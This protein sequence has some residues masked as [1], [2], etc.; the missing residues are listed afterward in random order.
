MERR[1]PLYRNVL[2]LNHQPKTVPY[3][4]TGEPRGDGEANYGF[5]DVKGRFD[6]LSTIPE[7]V[8]DGSLF[9]LVEAISAPETGLFS[10]GCV[11]GG[12]ADSAGHRR[13]GYVE[14]A[15]NSIAAVSSAASYFPLYFYFDQVL[16]R[17][18]LCSDVQY[19]WELKP[20]SFMDLGIQGYTCAVFVNT[21][22]LKT[23]AEALAAWA[24]ALDELA[25]FLSRVPA[26]LIDPMYGPGSAAP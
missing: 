19:V 24:R 2:Q 20:A 3:S 14:F 25:R 13:S 5:K 17:R 26:S 18:Q 4:G 22:C 21:P 15:L 7:L 23:E 9:R 8:R 11:S 6:L 12:A 16:S 1:M 10:I